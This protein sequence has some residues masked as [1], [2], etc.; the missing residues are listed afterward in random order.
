MAL[1]GKKHATT[2]IARMLARARVALAADPL[3]H[4]DAVAR[5]GGFSA[6]CR[7]LGT[8]E[9]EAA[10]RV[11]RH[12]GGRVG[13][14]PMIRHG[15]TIVNADNDF[16][17][18]VI[19]DGCHLGQGALLDLADRIELGD[20]IA[21]ADRAMLLTHT[22]AGESRSPHAL[23]T[24]R[25][26]PIR[27]ADD[28]YIGTGAI[29]LPGVAIGAGAVVGAGSVVTRDVPPGVVVAGNPARVLARSAA[30]MDAPQGKATGAEGVQQPN[31]SP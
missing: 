24:R 4:A 17:H 27:I 6:V 14:R 21:I 28:A 22:N 1:A 9:G 12:Y 16:E 25:A 13:I 31:R 30:N 8:S 20:R 15:L 29:V 23:A 7:L 11:I 18:L 19:G 2:M 5:Q 3:R 26:A 10:A